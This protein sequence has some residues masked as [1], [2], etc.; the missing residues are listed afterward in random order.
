MRPHLL[1]VGQHDLRDVGRKNAGDG[2]SVVG[3]FEDDAVV[4]RQALAK[5][6]R[7]SP[8]RGPRNAPVRRRRPRHRRSHGMRPVRSI[9]PS[10]ASFVSTMYE[11]EAAGENG[12][13][14]FALTNAAPGQVAGAT[15]YTNGIMHPTNHLGLPDRVLPEPLSRNLASSYDVRPERGRCSGSI[16]MPVRMKVRLWTASVPCGMLA[17]GAGD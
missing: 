13:C 17:S 7:A 10:A 5:T 12:T 3:R 2:Q 14:G 9:S 8:P 15:T 1:R 11:R 4:G 6:L 16:L